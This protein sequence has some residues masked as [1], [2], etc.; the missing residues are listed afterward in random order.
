MY[1]NL[2]HIIDDWFFDPH[3]TIS[4]VTGLAINVRYVC[5]R[6]VQQLLTG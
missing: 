4:I 2:V 3:Q 6:I 1:M 5:M